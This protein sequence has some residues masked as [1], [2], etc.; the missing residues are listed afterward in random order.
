M[1]ST[2][3]SADIVFMAKS[4]HQ[5]LARNVR[6]AAFEFQKGPRVSV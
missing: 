3:S 6:S 2:S 4:G 5:G 1:E